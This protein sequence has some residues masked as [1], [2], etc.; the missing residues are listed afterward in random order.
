MPDEMARTITG[1]W[2]KVMDYKPTDADARRA[3]L[4]SPEAGGRNRMRTALQDLKPH[5]ADVEY[6]LSVPNHSAAGPD[7]IPFAAYS[8]L[9]AF[10]VIVFYYAVSY[11]HLT[12]PT[13]RIV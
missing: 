6:L 4:N 1:H 3:W 7:H 13:K 11:T 10:G 8:S 12:L 5:I 9:G 2:Q